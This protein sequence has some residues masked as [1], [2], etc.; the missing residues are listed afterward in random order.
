MGKEKI[1]VLGNLA[2]PESLLKENFVK[3]SG[4]GGQNINKVATAIQLFCDTSKIS[5]LNLKSRHKLKSLAG[6]NMTKQGILV[7]EANRFRTQISNRKD[8]RQRLLQ[9]LRKALVADKVRIKTRAP[10]AEKLKRLKNK[11]RNSELKRRRSHR[12]EL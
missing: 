6:N 2:V 3:S 7:I 1:Q 12:I 9:L 10:K 11:K 4:P 5:W 8:A